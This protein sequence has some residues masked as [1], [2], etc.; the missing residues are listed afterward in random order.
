MSA[1]YPEDIPDGLET[2]PCL[3]CG[4][5]HRRTMGI[6]CPPF[7]LVRCA[8]CGLVY[9]SPRLSEAAMLARYRNGDYFAGRDVGYD[10]YGRQ[11]VSLRATFR[12]FLRRLAARGLAG[13]RLLEIGAGHGFLLDEAR[14]MFIRREGTEFDPDGDRKAAARADRV[15]R[16]GIEAV[17]PGARFDLVIANQV[18][19]HV[20]DPVGFLAAIKTRI[21]AGGALVLATPWMNGFWFRILGRRWPSFKIPEHVAFYDPDCLRELMEN[22]G[23]RYGGRIPYPHAFP[24][25]LI[26]QKL[27]L[28]LPGSLARISAWLPATTVAVYGT[29]EGQGR[30]KT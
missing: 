11:E 22:A 17:P 14:D 29:V 8:D 16:G 12:R 27:G 21:N 20:Y 30:R 18:I 10:D 19:E 15:Y 13:G 5:T 7:G 2:V 4:S 25:G 3:L 6:P 9:L 28:R 24:L 1:E 23:Y 26:A